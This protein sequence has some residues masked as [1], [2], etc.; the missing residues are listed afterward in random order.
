MGYINA[1]TQND[2][3]RLFKDKTGVT[4]KRS[5]LIGERVLGVDYVTDH[6]PSFKV[7]L[8]ILVLA[9][10]SSSAYRTAR[11]RYNLPNNINLKVTPVIDSIR[12]SQGS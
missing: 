12:Q 9:K 4:E 1:S 8:V 3:L 7:I 2:A 11:E 5:N 10:S 6:K